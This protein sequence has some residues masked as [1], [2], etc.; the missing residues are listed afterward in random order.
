MHLALAEVLGVPHCSDVVVAW[1]DSD[2]QQVDALLAR[3]GTAP[4][5]LLH[6][7]PK[8]NY[9]MWHRQGW[10]EVA[11]WLS[12]RGHLIALSGGAEPAELEYVAAL[13]AL[14]P[15]ETINAAGRLSFGASACLASRAAIYVGPD[16]AMTHVAA[17]LGVPSVALFGP[18]NP[19]KWGPWPRGHDASSNPW[20]RYG[21][22]R[23]G[24]VTILQGSG[25]CI[26]CRLEG[27][28]RSVASFSDCL[29]RLPAEKVIAAIAQR[30]DETRTPRE[31]A[32]A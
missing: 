16:T 20:R 4:L 14:M 12:M 1:T 11:R 26:P 29:Q 32:A 17:A 3:A 28:A 10:V 2:R 25:A 15:E 24:N 22:Q 23:S 7:Y 13:A 6:P 31:G 27:C 5:A 9:K 18:S 30:L 21:S 19:V 8:Y